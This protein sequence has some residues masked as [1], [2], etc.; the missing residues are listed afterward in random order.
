MQVQQ[1]KTCLIDMKE[2]RSQAAVAQELRG[3]EEA[4]SVAVLSSKERK[5]SIA[6]AVAWRA[7]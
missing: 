6:E 2:H 7:L 1:L 4:A 3:I 5:A